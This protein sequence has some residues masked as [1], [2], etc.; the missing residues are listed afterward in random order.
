MPNLELRGAHLH[1]VDAGHGPDVVLLLHAFPLHAGMWSEQVHALSNGHRV[2]AVDFSGFGE[3][4]ARAA[5]STLADHA[6]DLLALCDHLRIPSAA[7]VGLSMGGYVA[8][9][10]LRAR[11]EFVRALVLCDT[12]ATAD[13]AEAAAKRE[14][15]AGEALERG[16]G[17]V[18]EQLL[19]KLLGPHADL[20][21]KNAVF[22]MIGQAKPDAV[23]DAQFAMAARRDATDLLPAITCPTL[24][25]VG[26]EDAITPPS[27]AR[28]MAAAIPHARLH[29]LHA[30]G[31]LSN[32]E[33]RVGF[34]RALREF[35]DHLPKHPPKHG[36]GHG[37]GHGPAPVPV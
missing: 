26:S 36:H 21:L 14:A 11:P 18:A 31:H 6:A 8:F 7:I 34:N 4:T 17:W 37:H 5:G 33:A 3:S 27:D 13:T 35:L 22:A 24:V 15:F 2:L 20:R 9:E 29:E 12:R 32:L 16:V 1:Y 30:A 23:A 28:A 10:V 19:P 25:L